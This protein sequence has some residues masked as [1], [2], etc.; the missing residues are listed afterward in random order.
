MP[1]VRGCFPDAARSRVNYVS[2]AAIDHWQKIGIIGGLGPLACANFYMRLV[3]QTTAGSD[4][5]HP[6]VLLLSSPAIPSR[7]DHLL[8][9]G[10]SPVEQLQAVARRLQDAGAQLIAMPSVTTQAYYDEVSAAVDVPVVD[11]LRVVAAGLR[12][13]GVLRPALA[14]TDGALKLGLLHRALVDA[15][16][17]PVYPD[18]ATQREI[19]ECVEMVKSGRVQEAS[20]QL[21]KAVEGEWTRPGDGVVVGCTDLSPLLP[22]LPP[23]VYDV[24]RILGRAVLDMAASR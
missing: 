8:S 10:P 1:S 18:P 2:N 4:Q 13:A 20:A 11:M 17:T 9:D 12:E 23:H 16:L 15:G 5:E 24:T 7:L 6:E 22:E 21:R 3:E 14:V 19:Q